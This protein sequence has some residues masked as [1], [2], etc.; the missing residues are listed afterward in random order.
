[1]GLLGVVFVILKLCGEIDWPWWLVT[2]PF[3]AVFAFLLLA[4]VLLWLVA[5]IVY[6][7]KKVR[8][9]WART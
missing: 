3:W 2:L 1:M 4:I 8:Q 6:L 9:A 7:C 5:G